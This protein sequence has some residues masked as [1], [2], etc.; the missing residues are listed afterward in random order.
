MLRYLNNNQ[1]S[2][3]ISSATAESVRI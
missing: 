3:R 1:I 2:F